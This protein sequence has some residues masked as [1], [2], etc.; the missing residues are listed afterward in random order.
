MLKAIKMLQHTVGR[1]SFSA[2][3]RVKTS[4]LPCSF[5]SFA[6]L[7]DIIDKKEGFDLIQVEEDIWDDDFCEAIADSFSYNEFNPIDWNEFVYS[8]NIPFRI[9]ARTL[10]MVSNIKGKDSKKEQ[11]QILCNFFRYIIVKKPE[12]L[13]KAFY[14]SIGQIYP[15][16]QH[17]EL[18]LGKESFY[19]IVEKH[20]G[21]TAKE[22]KTSEKAL[23]GL[24]ETIEK[25]SQ[26]EKLIRDYSL[27]I[28]YV[29][30]SLCA[31]AKINGP[32]S[33][34]LKEAKVLSIL[35]QATCIEAK[36]LIRIMQQSLKIG[37]SQITLISSLAKA[38]WMTPPNQE[39]PHSSIE[40][41]DSSSETFEKEVQDIISVCPDYEKLISAM[42]KHS[43]GGEIREIL[44]FCQMTAGIPIK[45]MT[46]QPAKTILDILSRFSNQKLTCE[47]KY[48]G[49]RGQIHI[50]PDQTIQIF[51]R[52]NENLTEM[53][54]DIIETLKSLINFAKIQSCILDCEIVAFDPILN[55]V[56][57]F[58]ELQ[59]RR[60]GKIL[61][62]NVEIPVCVFIFDLILLNEKVLFQEFLQVRRNLFFKNFTEITGK[63]EFVQFKDLE[64]SEEIES[65][66]MN[67]VGNGC[68]GLMVKSLYEGSEYKPGERSFNWLKLKKDYLATEEGLCDSLDL[69]PIGAYFGKGKRKGMY[70]S[71]LLAVYDK[72]SQEFQTIC[73]IGTGFTDELLKTLYAEMKEFELVQQNP[74][75]RTMMKADVW[76]EPINVWEVKCADLSISPVHTSAWSKVVENKGISLRFP[77]FLRKRTDKSLADATSA[78]QVIE[79]YHGQFLKSSQ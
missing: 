21:K 37:A 71:F 72:S 1:S 34:S 64:S 10:E 70:G 26:E 4:F 55:Q 69:V 75:V 50:L 67:S 8:T 40:S 30:D 24:G 78:S 47:Y 73:K 57:S 44:K 59:H 62:E 60:R 15:D 41:P 76:F 3:F 29:Y 9:L 20:T 38:V 27:A 22:V 2:D 77:R 53:Y 63:F 18:G 56:K 66:L 79:L 14:L 48:D 6:N 12:I 17:I 68:E 33:K 13:Y 16:Y 32:S 61:L 58:N 5:R 46:A 7:N 11:K 42:L 36:Y 74:N 31:I 54:P 65:F 35:S 19:K 49:I 28:E 51:S 39:Y 23:G 45:P 43:P 25:L 52:G